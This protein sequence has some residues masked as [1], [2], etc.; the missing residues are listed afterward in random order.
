MYVYATGA[1]G[2]RNMSEYLEE[3]ISRVFGDLIAE[4]MLD[5]VADD[6]LIGGNDIQELLSTWYRVLQRLIENGLTISPVKTIICPK[7]VKILGW[8]W[9]NGTISVD[10]HRI[11]PL[12]VCAVPETV[13][14]L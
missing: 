7:V 3:I 5:K 8:I 12:T 10:R 9:D 1:M 2:L 4:G 6:H 14:Q 13:K 11:N